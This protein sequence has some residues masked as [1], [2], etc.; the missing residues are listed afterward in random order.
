M[1]EEIEKTGD[2]QKQGNW[3]KWV[4]NACQDKLD[5]KHDDLEE[6]QDR[7]ERLEEQNDTFRDTL[8]QAFGSGYRAPAPQSI[9]PE[10][11]GPKNE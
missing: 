2:P 1:E 8:L 4:Q 9:E 6:L 3:S 10:D 11:L 7:V 5:A